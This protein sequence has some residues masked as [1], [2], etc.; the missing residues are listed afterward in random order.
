M[1]CVCSNAFLHNGAIKQ[2]ESYVF[3]MEKLFLT[4]TF[5]KVQVI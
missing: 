2:L 4:F 1:F 5:K 3:S